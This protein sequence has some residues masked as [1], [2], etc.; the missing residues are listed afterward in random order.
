MKPL[1]GSP[2]GLI[3]AL[4]ASQGLAAPSPQGRE[5]GLLLEGAGLVAGPLL[6]ARLSAE[7]G[8]RGLGQLSLRYGGADLEA[9]AAWAATP[10]SPGRLT[11]QLKHRALDE[12]AAR[13]ALRLPLI[14]DLE[15]APPCAASARPDLTLGLGQARLMVGAEVSP[16]ASRGPVV[17][18]RYGAG[19]TT[20]L[21]GDQLSLLV[22]GLAQQHPLGGARL[23][24]EAGLRWLWRSGWLITLSGQRALLTRTTSPLVDQGAPLWALNLGLSW[25]PVHF[26][27]DRD[28]IEDEVDRCPARPEDHDGFED[29]DGCPDLD[30]DGDRIPDVVDRCPNRREI[31]NRRLD[32]D[33][34]PDVGDRDRDGRL[35]DVDDCPNHPEDLDGFED[36]DGCPELDNDQDGVPDTQDR[37]V[38]AP[39]DVDGFEDDDGCPDPDNDRDGILDVD[40]PWPDVPADTPPLTVEPSA[41][42]TSAPASAPLEPSAP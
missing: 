12:D 17:D 34:C 11:L 36:D 20:P 39:E 13:L 26:D 37:C 5:S 33:G 15:P 14:V 6:G 3:A 23:T 42:P 41:T 8:R 24:A 35:D 27:L 9:G 29:Q 16:C 7:D 30:N 21:Y 40:D 31:Y 38:W 32:E 22:D 1:V 18:L 25:S 19:W 28:G 4:W 10:T 2:W